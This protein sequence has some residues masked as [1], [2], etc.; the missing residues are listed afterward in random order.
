MMHRPSSTPNLR[1][2]IHLENS[3]FPGYFANDLAVMYKSSLQ[4]GFGHMHQ[5]LGLKPQRAN[6]SRSQARHGSPGKQRRRRSNAL[7]LSSSKENNGCS[8]KGRHLAKS[9]T[10]SSLGS[11]RF[12]PEGCKGK[13]FEHECEESWQCTTNQSVAAVLR[14]AITNAR[15]ASHKVRANTMSSL[16]S[17]AEKAEHNRSFGYRSSDEIFEV[18]DPAASGVGLAESNGLR[19]A[20]KRTLRKGLGDEF[21]DLLASGVRTLEK[22]DCQRTLW[23]AV[24]QPDAAWN[25]QGV[26][27]VIDRISK[28][29]A[30][31]QEF[32]VAKQF[33]EKFNNVS[34]VVS[35]C[36]IQHRSVSMSFDEEQQDS[37]AST[38]K[39]ATEAS[40]TNAFSME[41]L[42]PADSQRKLLR[43]KQES[44]ARNMGCEDEGEVEY[45][46]G[47]QSLNWLPMA[48]T[49][50]SGALR[51]RMPPLAS[52]VSEPWA[53]DMLDSQPSAKAAWAC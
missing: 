37:G 49:R 6:I 44:Q 53:A 23:H 28:A 35:L 26:Q 17:N 43:F 39:E 12:E 22:L 2:S 48:R 27:D 3:P 15:E 31:S 5:P 11:L 29:G 21:K 34:P 18:N 50:S 33:L 40:T 4:N 10:S 19:I 9:C 32:E 20:I 24:S 30:E 42:M 8:I 52:L 47:T 7:E 14:T 46:S 16:T 38:P 25:P 51:R 1:G 36:H 41:T 45:G 13:R